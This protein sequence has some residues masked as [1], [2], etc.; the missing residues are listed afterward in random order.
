MA[1]TNDDMAG[2]VSEPNSGE[3]AGAPEVRPDKPLWPRPHDEVSLDGDEA[4]PERVEPVLGEPLGEP[5]V[6]PRIEP[7]IE[8]A[9]VPHVEPAL[10]AEPGE[11]IFAEAEPVPPTVAHA[12]EPMSVRV[13]EEPLRAAPDVAPLTPP[14][15]VF[16]PRLEVAA[17]AV[18]APARPRTAEREPSSRER[19]AAAVGADAAPRRNRFLFPALA[20]LVLLL[21]GGG[22]LYAMSGS[23]SAPQTAAE[24]GA[25]K[26]PVA[27]PGAVPAPVAGA[28][29]VSAEDVRLIRDHLDQIEKRFARVESQ[30]AEKTTAA[31]APA[32]GEQQRLS[33]LTARLDRLERATRSPAA[34][35]APTAPGTASAPRV[36]STTPT[37]NGPVPAPAP[38][39]AAAPSEPAT[40]A[41]ATPEPIAA[42]T[43]PAVPQPRPAATARAEP[44]AEPQAPKPEPAAPSTPRVA[45][46]SPD[47]PVVSGWQV[48]DVYNGMAVLQSRRGIMEVTAGDELP[49]G[50]RVLAI[51][52][53]GGKWVVVTEQGVIAN[54]Q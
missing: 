13:H 41:A 30:L 19:R 29:A 6:E 21:G 44:R 17:P 37:S 10:A 14:V 54:A 15:S 26:A 8:S 31:P 18:E 11:A 7:V 12:P 53:L 49:D 43:P 23:G 2:I 38:A 22:L 35:A 51:R 9:A 33:E 20:A 16:T 25:A 3:G 34:E 46:A 48:R 39:P 42:P 24:T 45:T 4:Q 32:A 5:V 36:I 1:H 28:S 50:N 27:V 40:T 47:Q 52:R